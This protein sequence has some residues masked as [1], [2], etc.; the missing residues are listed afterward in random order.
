MEKLLPCLPWPCCP[1]YLG[2]AALP[3]LA[4]LPCLPW[5]CCPAYLGPA[6]V[7]TLALLPCL[8]W[9]CCPA[10]LGLDVCYLALHLANL[11]LNFHHSAVALDDLVGGWGAECSMQLTS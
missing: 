5:P 11:S 2:P 9:P 7:P 6:T 4:L 8:P 3:S 10:Y 1:A